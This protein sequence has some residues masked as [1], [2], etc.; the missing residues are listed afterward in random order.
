[1]LGDAPHLLSCSRCYPCPR[2]RNDC[3][4]D[5]PDDWMTTSNPPLDARVK[6]VGLRDRRADPARLRLARH[7]QRRALHGEPDLPGRTDKDL[8]RAADYINWPKC[9]GG[10][11]PWTVTDRRLAPAARGR[12]SSPHARAVRR[13]G[14]ESARRGAEAKPHP[15]GLPD[16]ATLKKMRA[17]ATGPPQAA[18]EVTARAPRCPRTRPARMPAPTTPTSSR[19]RS[20]RSTR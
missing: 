10:Q 2:W 16:A 17:S 8:R 19:R 20:A 12:L 13:A 18:R 15:R 11:L 5:A 3:A 9:A 14:H 7:Q 1:M 6:P 4:Q